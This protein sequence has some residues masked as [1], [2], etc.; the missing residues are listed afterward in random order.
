MIGIGV[1]TGIC[2]GHIF[3]YEKKTIIVEKVSVTDKKLELERFNTNLN[4]SEKQIQEIIR[5][6]NAEIGQ[7]FEAH[8]EILRDP[9]MKSSIE[10]LITDEAINA[11]YAVKQVIDGYVTMF[12]AIE[13]EYIRERAAD[14]KDIAERILNNLLG[15]SEVDLKAINEPTIFLAHDLT[16]SET[17]QLNKK[18][19]LGFITEIGGKTSHSAIMARTLE[20]P[21]IV[22]IGD[23]FPTLNTRDFVLMNG[24]TGEFIINPDDETVASFE[25]KKLALELERDIWSQFKSK[26]SV[27]ASGEHIEIAANIGSAEDLDAVLSKGAEGIGLFRTEF[28]YMGK[29]D[30]PDEATQ[31]GVYKAVL[32]RMG[33][34]PVVIRTLDIGGD[35]ELDYFDMPKELNPFLGNRAIRLCLCHKDMFK[36]QL[37]ALLKS[38]IYGNLHI[39]LPMIATVDELREA[40][41]LI[42]EV[43]NELKAENIEV[44]DYKL[45]IMLEIP[46]AVFAA[47]ILA[48]EVDFF[49]IGTNDLI[50]YTFAADR[51]NDNVSY[52]YQPY[53][54][55]L[56]NMIDFVSKAAHKAGIWVGM[57]GEMCSEV[58]AIPL[59][60]GLGLDELSMNAS[61]ILKTR[62]MM[63]KINKK[64]A[65][66]LLDRALECENQA[67]VLA[68]TEEYLGGV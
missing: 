51:M 1:S 3:K 68:L 2:S 58:N 20:I 32:E 25:E 38:S 31:L 4:I 7:I 64:D 12:E 36:V 9:E 22:G 21:A 5:N 18:Y 42:Q 50:Q 63:S 13:D 34:K 26:K 41:E 37:R 27:T 45:G 8:L 16:P 47:N 10:G 39:M 54:P 49:S 11:E 66:A 33:D 24:E 61:S 48:K 55:S 17:A 60:I 19:V 29:S 15:H 53:N 14:L 62:Y 65:E 43:E 35:K 52:L 59:L 46:A 28:L 30:F 67:Q 57:C 44:A 56:L 6:S 23:V 40:K